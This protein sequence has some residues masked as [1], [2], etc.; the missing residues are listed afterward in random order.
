MKEEEW[1]AGS[2]MMGPRQSCYSCSMGGGLA[3]NEW[4]PEMTVNTT[5]EGK[6]TTSDLKTPK[7][8]Y[9]CSS[10]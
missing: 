10:L 2:N 9:E 5:P 1:C 8:D 4:E 6:V 7:V 3:D